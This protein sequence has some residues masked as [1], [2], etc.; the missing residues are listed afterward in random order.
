[1]VQFGASYAYVWREAWAG[2]GPNASGAGNLPVV[3]GLVT[4]KTINNVV[5]TTFR[6]YLP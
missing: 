4:P 1:M 5:L 3:T 2:R 6:Y